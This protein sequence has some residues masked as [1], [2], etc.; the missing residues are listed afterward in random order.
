METILEKIIHQKKK[1]VMLKESLI[2]RKQLEN[3]ELFKRHTFS[4]SEQIKT[5][6][7]GFGIIAEHKRR[8]PSRSSI[9]TSLLVQEV[10][11]AYEN[12]G[13][14][15]ASILTDNSFFGGS[16]EDL[17][18]ARATVKLPLLRK[19]FIIEEYQVIE[20]K[21]FGADAI[22]LIAATLTKQKVNSLTKLA[23]N[24]GL[25]VLLEVHNFKEL[26]QN[27]DTPVQLMGVNNRNLKTFEV[28][29]E[30]S[31]SL[32]HHIPDGVVK[33]SES[34]INSA[35]AIKT[36]YDVGYDGFLIGEH[37]MKTNDPEKEVKNF[38]HKICQLIPKKNES[39][40]QNLRHETP[41]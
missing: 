37:F 25:E 11:E 33:I 6:P 19:D 27:I 36:L 13:V 20:A 28:S 1:E 12:A 41:R 10:L 24:L 3:S 30:N 23:Q 14:N 31:L 5:S 9:N 39:K 4:L 22:L 40:N 8:S 35:E 15:G 26:E 16:L 18:L 21:A 32:V 38:I 2:S 29:L 17:L 34:G 7:L